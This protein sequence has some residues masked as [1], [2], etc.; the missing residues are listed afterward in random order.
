MIGK[1]V[2]GLDSGVIDSE[3]HFTPDVVMLLQTNDGV[4]ILVRETG[5]APNVFQ[6]FETSSNATTNKYD[7]LN[8]V[9]A[10][11]KAAQVTGGVVVDVWKVS[12]AGPP[13]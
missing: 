2:G 4:D 5:R 11:G 13:V 3:K 1:V 7:Y 8:D 10:Y 6:L 12:D 9:V